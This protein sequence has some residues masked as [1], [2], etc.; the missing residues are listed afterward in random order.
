MTIDAK[1]LREAIADARDAALNNS[2]SHDPACTSRVV[3]VTMLNKLIAAASA[4]LASLP[5]EV[6][7]TGKL[8]HKDGNF[9]VWDLN[10]VPIDAW[11]DG[12]ELTFSGTALLP[13]EK[14]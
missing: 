6:S 11:R 5:R 3:S 1:E 2:T 8:R 4:H 10:G 7:Y 9:V 12:Q 13:R 14:D